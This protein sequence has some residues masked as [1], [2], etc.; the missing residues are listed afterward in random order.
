MQ[1]P[2]PGINPLSPLPTQMYTSSSRRRDAA[3]HGR[4]SRNSHA[5]RFDGHDD[6]HDPHGYHNDHHR[7]DYRDGRNNY[8]QS[9]STS[10]TRHHCC[11]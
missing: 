6:P 11:H 2:P 3:D 10:D 5:I 8:N 1:I 7:H 4:Y 9:R